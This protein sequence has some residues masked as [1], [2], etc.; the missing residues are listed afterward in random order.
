MMNVG[1]EESDPRQATPTGFEIGSR[2]SRA[3]NRPP[4]RGSVLALNSGRANKGT[5]LKPRRGGLFIARDL[6]EAISNPVGVTCRGS[7]SRVPTPIF[8]PARAFTLIELLVVIA[9]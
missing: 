4:L 8:N 6:R 5:H 3:I 9:I 1:G 2:R 7:D